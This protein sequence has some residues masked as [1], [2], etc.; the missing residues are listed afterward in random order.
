MKAIDKNVANNNNSVI[1]IKFW[2]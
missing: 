1:K 2:C